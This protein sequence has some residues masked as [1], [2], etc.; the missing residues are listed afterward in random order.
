MEYTNCKSCGIELQPDE[1]LTPCYDDG[2]GLDS[3]DVHLEWPSYPYCEF[4]AEFCDPQLPQEST[5]IY[6][7]ANRQDTY[8]EDLPF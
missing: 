7:F 8:D 6:R 5:F 2:G 1:I 4:C 3:F